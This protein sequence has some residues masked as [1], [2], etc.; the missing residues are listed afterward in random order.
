MKYSIE[1][2]NKQW[3]NDYL[4][5]LE[6]LS[7]DDNDNN[8]NQQFKWKIIKEIPAVLNQ[9]NGTI[10]FGDEKDN[11]LEWNKNHSLRMRASFCQG[12]SFTSFSKSITLRIDQNLS[13]SKII[14]NNEINTL[15]SFLPKGKE[16]KV[17]LLYRGSRDGFGVS[18]FHEKCDNKGATVTIVLSDQFNHVFGG[19]TNLQW[20]SRNTY[21]ND[22]GA[23]V[24]LLRSG[25]GDNP[26]KFTIKSG[27]EQHAIYDYSSYG[28]TFGGGHD[29]HI[30]DNCNSNTNNYCNPYSY[31][32]PSDNTRLAGARN[33]KVKEIEVYLVEW[34]DFWSDLS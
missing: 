34:P 26:Q 3:K 22:A 23:F 27:Q 19:F 29:F 13:Y 25:K 32:G 8:D 10:D 24:Y 9:S 15:L 21:A 12:I 5:Q 11:L 14:N 6:I 20:T 2:V 31:N 17:T 4:Y 16:S 33:F 7:F 30:S 1:K 28:P 18:D